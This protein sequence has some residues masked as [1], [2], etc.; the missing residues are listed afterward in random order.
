MPAIQDMMRLLKSAPYSQ[1]TS[2]QHLEALRLVFPEPMET[3]PEMLACFEQCRKHIASITSMPV[4]TRFKEGMLTLHAALAVAY[5]DCTARAG[6]S[7]AQAMRMYLAVNLKL[8][9]LLI[10]TQYA[11][12]N[13][14]HLAGGRMKE[15]GSACLRSSADALYQFTVSS[16]SPLTHAA[17]SVLKAMDL[18]IGP[19][20]EHYYHLLLVKVCH[21]LLMLTEPDC[22]AHKLLTEDNQVRF[23]LQRSPETKISNKI[24]CAYE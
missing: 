18:P 1:E 3:G 8:T 19:W 2:S 10:S 21:F 5:L 17:A 11:T 4:G 20:E 16:Y 6:L 13:T 24:H 15:L 23:Y 12:F 9:D 14:H 7:A 22:V